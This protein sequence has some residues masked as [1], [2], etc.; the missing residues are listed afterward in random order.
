MPTPPVPAL[1]PI[2]PNSRPAKINPD[3]SALAPEDRKAQEQGQRQQ[4]ATLRRVHMVTEAAHKL[5]ASDLGIHCLR[6]LWNWAP[7]FDLCRHEDVLV[8]WRAVGVVS[9][10][11]A[12][13]ERGRRELQAAVGA[14]EYRAGTDALHAFHVVPHDGAI[15]EFGSGGKEIPTASAAARAGSSDQEVLLLEAGL[16]LSEDLRQARSALVWGRRGVSLGDE[17]VLHQQ[18]QRARLPSKARNNDAVQDPAVSEMASSEAF[19]SLP[20][21]DVS[22]DHHPA[23]ADIGGILHVTAAPT[24][25]GNCLG[26]GGGAA[27]RT[28]GRGPPRL[29]PTATAQR[30]VASLSLAMTVARPILLHGPVG[31]GKSLLAREVARLAGGQTNS[32]ESGYSASTSMLE[33][34]LDDQTDS[35]SLLGAHACTDVP[36]EF[37]WRPGALTRAAAAGTW[38]LIEDLDR[39]PFEVCACYICR[40]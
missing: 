34:H 17:G 20:Q 23:V 28:G 2:F 31:C 7:F 22:Y 9:L 29:V 6:Q 13:D 5:L 14:S 35:K 27:D 40:L 33:L 37:A 15:N 4:E 36:G 8:R 26:R 11:L 39:A 25:D 19:P 1:L 30:N 18:Q 32:G 3:V 24:D 16:K 21:A 12:L 10:L 38:V